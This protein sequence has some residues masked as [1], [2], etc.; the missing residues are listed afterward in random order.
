VTLMFG[1]YVTV[2]G[3]MTVCPVAGAAVMIVPP[4][5]TGVDAL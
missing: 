2:F 4:F 3:P 5:A 1:V